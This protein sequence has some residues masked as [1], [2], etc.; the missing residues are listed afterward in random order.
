M[1]FQ[2]ILIGVGAFF[3]AI[4]RFFISNKVQTF[5]K[6]SFF[7]FGTLFINLSGC[8]VMGILTGAIM[9]SDLFDTDIQNLLITGFIATY[10]T[11]STFSYE[12]Y[13]LIRNRSFC[14]A[15]INIFLQLF[16]GI[17]LIWFGLTIAR[18]MF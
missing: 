11:F 16:V 9:Y 17:I 8:L 13:V 10:T 1:L 6:S 5:S 7:P 12:T 3:G 2:C 4:A 18:F 14:I 15:I